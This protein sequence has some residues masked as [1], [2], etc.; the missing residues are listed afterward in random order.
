MV[1]EQVRFNKK[2]RADNTSVVTIQKMV[3]RKAQTE[4]R[5]KKQGF[6]SIPSQGI[7]LP[8]YN[9]AYSTAGLNA[10]ANYANRSQNDLEGD[11]IPIMGQRNYGLAAHNFNDGRTGFSRLQESTNHLG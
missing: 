9:D 8:I 7:L 6:V 11:K 10:G 1:R 3:M 5:L 2:I 4:Q